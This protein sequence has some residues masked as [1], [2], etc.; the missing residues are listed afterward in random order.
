MFGKD[1]TLPLEAESM[2]ERIGPVTA[3]SAVARLSDRKVYRSDQIPKAQTSGL[4]TY[5]ARVS[6][7]ETVGATIHSG[8]WLNGA[9]SQYP[10]VVLGSSA[11]ERLGIGHA[12]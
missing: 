10:A 2:I 12:G 9:T 5:A 11:A 3:T 1:A 7:P 8:T 4:S 6:L